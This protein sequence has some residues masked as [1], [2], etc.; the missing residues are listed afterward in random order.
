MNLRM[1]RIFAL[2]L[3]VIMLNACGLYRPPSSPELFTA[4]QVSDL[5]M[6]FESGQVILS[7]SSPELDRQGKE[8]RYLEGY[9]ILRRGPATRAE[10]FKELEFQ[11][12]AFVEDTHLEVLKKEREN[13][14]SAGKISRKVKIEERSKQFVFKDSLSG[15]QSIAQYQIIP[16]SNGFDGLPSNILQIQ[17]EDDKASI[18]T[19]KLENSAK[20]EREE[21]ARN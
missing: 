17:L 8:L 16:I 9:K 10:D 14:I 12:I 15:G 5:K 1:N 2:F 11:S 6:N 4:Q 7:W 19:L 3:F 20:K 18:L 21:G 13:A